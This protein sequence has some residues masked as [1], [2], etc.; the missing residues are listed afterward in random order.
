MQSEPVLW[1]SGAYFKT[2]A[3]GSVEEKAYKARELVE[4]GEFDYQRALDMEG[5]FRP[6]K[7]SSRAC[8]AVFHALVELTDVVLA[9]HGRVSPKNHEGRVNALLDVGRS[10][11]ADLYEEAMFRL[12]DQG[13]YEQKLWPRAKETIDRVKAMVEKELGPE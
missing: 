3:S 6:R 7:V 5:E 2:V 12:H 8:E 11:L 10:D 1:L 13:Y 4:E 9:R